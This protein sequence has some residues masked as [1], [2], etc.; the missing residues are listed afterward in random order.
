MNTKTIL[1]RKTACS[2]S[3]FFE[4]KNSSELDFV[5]KVIMFPYSRR[6]IDVILKRLINREKY[7]E[8]AAVMYVHMVHPLNYFLLKKKK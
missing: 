6:R 1:F 7:T 5:W 2:Y 3:T 8:V 4:K